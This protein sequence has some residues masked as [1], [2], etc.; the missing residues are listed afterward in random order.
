M[1]PAKI[2]AIKQWDTPMC[3]W[4]NCLF[5]GFCNFYRQFIRNFLNIAGPLNALTKKNM[6][7]A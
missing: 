2:E 5:I 1:D 7:F 4:K 6:P 3:V